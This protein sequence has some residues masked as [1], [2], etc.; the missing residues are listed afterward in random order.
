LIALLQRGEQ[1]AETSFLQLCKVRRP[2][3][4]ETFTSQLRESI[5]DLKGS[6]ACVLVSIVKMASD[7]LSDPAA[8]QASLMLLNKQGVFR[9]LRLGQLT[10]LK[11][12]PESLGTLAELLV[13]THSK[14]LLDDTNCLVWMEELLEASDLSGCAEY[15]PYLQRLLEDR[16]LVKAN[17]EGRDG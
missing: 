8:S 12:T 9:K 5:T 16:E 3:E 14:G 15:F 10:C 2:H 6:R 4:A 1:K 7:W 17:V 11:Q 13:W